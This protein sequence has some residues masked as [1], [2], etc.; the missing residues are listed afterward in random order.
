[1]PPNARMCMVCG[2]APPI[3]NPVVR[4]LRQK[5]KVKKF[6]KP[7]SSGR[8]CPNCRLVLTRN[9]AKCMACGWEKRPSRYFGKTPRLAWA[10]MAVVVVALYFVFQAF[11]VLA[12]GGHGID[13]DQDQYG[14]NRFQRNIFTQ[15]PPSTQ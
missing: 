11:V 14:R 8:P 5:K 2:W 3:K 13:P 10:S 4:Y 6:Q 9:A 7:G 12:A 15:A 1:M